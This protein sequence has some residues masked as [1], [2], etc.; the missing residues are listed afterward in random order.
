VVVGSTESIS[1]LSPT[2]KNVFMKELSLGDLDQEQTKSSAPDCLAS[3]VQKYR[4]TVRDRDDALTAA[5]KHTTT[6]YGGG[7]GHF[8]VIA[9]EA[10]KNA[11]LRGRAN[12]WLDVMGISSR[13]PLL[14][15]SGASA[16]TKGAITAGDVSKAISTYDAS[17]AHGPDGH[18]AGRASQVAPV[19]WED[20]GGLDRY[21]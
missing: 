7:Y 18:K 19:K 13:K 10:R 4:D 3:C 6:R 21:H 2:V 15:E 20:I 1:A 12:A 9:D 14:N 17:N 16:L 8:E 5:S 11:L